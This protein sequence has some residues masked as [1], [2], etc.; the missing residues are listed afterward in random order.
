MPNE[1]KVGDAAPAFRATAIGGKYGAGEEVTL[2][3]FKGKPLVLYFYPKDDTPGCTAQACGLRDAWKEIKD[4][5]AIFG[6]SPDSAK[7]HTRFI[8]KFQL[9]FPLLSDPD[10]EMLTTY[11]VWVQK[12]FLGKEYMGTERTTY[13]INPTGEIAA[14]FRRVKPGEHVDLV[15]NALPRNGSVR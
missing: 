3:N 10:H 4:R 12:N 6:V 7:S 8:E 9:P 14:I 5:A 2:A 15:K 13:V 1:L 11:G